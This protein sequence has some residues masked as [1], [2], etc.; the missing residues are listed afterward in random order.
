MTNNKQEF[1]IVST[2][3]SKIDKDSYVVV[4]D[5]YNDNVGYFF[6][7]L[8]GNDDI[9]TMDT[10]PIDE[11]IL[12]FKPQVGRYSLVCRSYSDKKNTS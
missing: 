4:S 5:I 2:R 9:M 6:S 7:Q 1:K 8:D 12:A 3:Q 10:L 11:F